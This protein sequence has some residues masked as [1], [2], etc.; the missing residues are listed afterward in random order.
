MGRAKLTGA[1]LVGLCLA[2]CDCG[3][4]IGNA[5]AGFRTTTT[6]IDFGRALEGTRI[7]RDLELT[8]TG[9]ADVTVEAVTAAPFS[10]A[11][12][13]VVPGGGTVRLTVSFTAAD[14]PAEGKL[15]LTAHGESFEV[16]LRGEGVRPLNCT[17][18]AACRESH[19]SLETK[20]CEETVS[21]DGASCVPDDL[22]L[23]EGVCKAGECLGTPRSCSDGNACTQDACSPDVGCIHVDISSQCPQPSNPCEHAVCD[24][25]SGCGTAVSA[26]DAIC[27]TVD[28]VTAHLCLA[29]ACREVPTPEGFLCAPATPC[30]GEGHCSMGACV[31]PDAGTMTPAWSVTLGDADPDAGV[32][33]VRNG[34]LAFNGN[35]YL[36]ACALSSM[37]GGCALLSYTSNGFVRFETPLGPDAT[38][39]AAGPFGAVVSA[40]GMVRAYAPSGGGEL[41][42]VDLPALL[43]GGGASL[44]RDALAV[45]ADGRIVA[46]VRVE[47]PVEAADGGAGDGGAGDGG[48]DDDGDGGAGV[49][50]DVLVELDGA[51]GGFLGAT[52]LPDAGRPVALALSAA[53]DAW[54]RSD[55][56]LSHLW[57]DADGGLLITSAVLEDAGVT[58]SA[59]GAGTRAFVGGAQAT[60][61]DGGIVLLPPL[62]NA[63]ERALDVEV[64]SGGGAAYLFFDVCRGAFPPPCADEERQSWIRAFDPATGA[65]LWEAEFLPGKANGE[66]VEAALPGGALTGAVATFT[67]AQF[68]SMGPRADLQLFANG[69]RLMSCPL[70]GT[71]RVRSALFDSGNLYV[72]L[73]RDGQWRLEAYA[74]QGTSLLQT[75]W[76]R[77]GGVSGTRRER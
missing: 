48:M 44:A 55:A 15:T 33:V 31:R 10:V 54:L 18:T 53:G 25:A 14:A 49:P 28:C 41:W 13:I 57:R 35:I 56:T 11:P 4:G 34:I 38:L 21:P 61:E 65:V 12:S 22:C 6:E 62:L 24:P 1:L 72:L 39:H 40:G 59:G 37:D 73:E 76:P 46:G 52:S 50:Q 36:P 51:D 17:P 77:S 68:E 2:A 16:L 45:T 8:G 75:G 42:A 66:L 69:A 74:L 27:G 47:P 23:E 9:R 32:P 71:P 70:E 29:G 63:G 5:T 7:D 43:G 64:L 60:F 67:R 3:G 20:R 30:Q 58:L 26:D 19:F